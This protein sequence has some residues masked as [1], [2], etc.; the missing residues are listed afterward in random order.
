MAGRRVNG[1]H[2]G[3]EEG[4][5]RTSVPLLS[6]LFLFLPTFFTLTDAWMS[7]RTRWY[8]SDDDIVKRW[9]ETGENKKE[10]KNARERSLES[11][12]CRVIRERFFFFFFFFSD[13]ALTTPFFFLA[14]ARAASSFLKS[15]HRALVFSFYSSQRC[16]RPPSRSW[17]SCPSSSGASLSS[18]GGKN[19]REREGRRERLCRSD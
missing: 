1:F 5:E 13:A 17:A 9:K 3:A 12:G 11:D 7:S 4:T 16:P 6:L 8:G 10:K 14:S 19:E 15:L 2:I 18:G